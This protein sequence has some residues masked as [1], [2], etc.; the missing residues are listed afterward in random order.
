VTLSILIT[1][2]LIITLIFHFIG[3]YV[4][5]QKLVWIAIV[6]LWAAAISFAT[7]EVKPKAYEAIK[8]MQGKYAETDKL[9][10]KAMPEVSLYELI[11][12]KNSY[13]KNKKLNNK[14]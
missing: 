4:N 1:I 11:Q 3:R 6:L 2:G 13:L 14:H 12:I 7:H 9:I 10:K 5:A 8:K